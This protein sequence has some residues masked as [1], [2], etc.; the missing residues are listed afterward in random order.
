M[1]LLVTAVIGMI[2]VVVESARAAKSTKGNNGNPTKPSDSVEE[3]KVS[4]SNQNPAVNNKTVPNPLGF[5]YGQPQV[6]PPTP[7][8]STFFQNPF[9]FNFNNGNGGGAPLMPPPPCM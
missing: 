3:N 8:P 7:G 2:V 1:I 9:N 6:N 5:P 4:P